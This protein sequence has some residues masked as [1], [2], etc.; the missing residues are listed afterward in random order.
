MHPTGMEEPAVGGSC[1]T[2]PGVFDGL[3]FV[4]NNITPSGWFT[5]VSTYPGVA[6]LD[7]RF[8]ILDRGNF[9]QAESNQRS[10]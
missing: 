1:L 10:S 2:R 6:F 8:V 4:F 7:P 5:P 3:S 9:E